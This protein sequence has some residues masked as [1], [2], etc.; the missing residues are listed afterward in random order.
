MQGAPRVIGAID[1]GQSNFQGASLNANG[2]GKVSGPV[3]FV[4]EQM[5]L[6]EPYPMNANGAGSC[7]PRLQDLGLKRGIRYRILNAAIGGARIVHFTGMEGATITGRDVPLRTYNANGAGISGGTGR[8][9]RFGHPDFDP[10]GLL[11]RLK[12]EMDKT[13]QIRDWVILWANGESEGGTP[14][15]MYSEAIESLGDFAINVLGC[16]LFM[17]GFSAQGTLSRSKLNEL[18]AAVD[19]SIQNMQALGMNVAAGPNLFRYFNGKCPL[20]PEGNP[21]VRVHLEMLAQ[22]TQAKLIDRHLEA[23]GY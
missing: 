14:G 23:A 1:L 10:Y 8:I 22:A 19:T 3:N 2:S 4:S 13:P 12:P 6:T 7:W 20:Y 18:S 15:A 17:P 5:G 16:S 11:A 9:P 21:I